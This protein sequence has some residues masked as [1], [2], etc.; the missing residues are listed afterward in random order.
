MLRLKKELLA[1]EES[2]L[3]SSKRPQS[4]HSVDYGKIKRTTPPLPRPGTAEIRSID[5]AGKGPKL[6]KTRGG[7]GPLATISHILPKLPNRALHQVSRLQSSGR[8]IRSR[9]N[10]ACSKTRVSISLSERSCGR[11]EGKDGR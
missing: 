8:F 11:S 9:W 3:G 10:W 7:G 1:E 2:D 6:T 4:L 5:F